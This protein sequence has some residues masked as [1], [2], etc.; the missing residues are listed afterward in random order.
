MRAGRTSAASM[1]NLQA[2]AGECA[3][4]SRV[5]LS[6]WPS[7]MSARHSPRMREPMMRDVLL[8]APRLACSPALQRAAATPTPF[9]PGCGPCKRPAGPRRGRGG[10]PF[11]RDS[12]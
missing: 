12:G 8:P 11:K 4:T 2:S 10:L 9:S 1:C 3:A 6:T 5:I 7:D